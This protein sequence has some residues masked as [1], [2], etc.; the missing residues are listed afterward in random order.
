MNDF[1][2]IAQMIEDESPAIKAYGEITDIKDTKKNGGR[3][4]IAIDS[5][6]AQH[7]MKNMV[8]G[9]DD[10]L[11]ILL[12]MVEKDALAETRERMKTDSDES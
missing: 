11:V 5:E 12:M 9:T 10:G 6:K 7:I 3:M 2:A 8:R 1:H 4:T